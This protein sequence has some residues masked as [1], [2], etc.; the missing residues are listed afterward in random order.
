MVGV[1]CC[2][3]LSEMNFGGSVDIKYCNVAGYTYVRKSCR[4]PA[5]S[6]TGRGCLSVFCAKVSTVVRKKQKERLKY[7]VGA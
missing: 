3:V 7:C 2:V 4:S 6:L 5:P 1:V